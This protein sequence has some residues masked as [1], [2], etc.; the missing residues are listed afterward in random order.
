MVGHALLSATRV[1][2]GA[3]SEFVFDQ[4]IDVDSGL[5]KNDT[6]SQT[7]AKALKKLDCYTCHHMRHTM[8][9]RLRNA[10]VPAIRAEEIGGWS[11]VSIAD[12]Y[13]EQT[14]LKNLQSDLLKT[15]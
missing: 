8:R 10:D 12:Q 1:V 3:S 14:A 9:T 7:L 15:L 2:S 11:R 6:A 13:G 5:V 4:Y